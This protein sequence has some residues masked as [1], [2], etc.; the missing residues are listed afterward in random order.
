MVVLSSALATLQNSRA[1]AVLATSGGFLAPVLSSTGDGSHIALFSYYAVLNLGILTIAWFRS[2]RMLNVLGFGFTFV[3]GFMWGLKSY[4]SKMFASAEFFLIIFFFFYVAIAL[5]FAQRQAPNLRGYVD[6]TLIFGVPVVAFSIQAALVKGI[7]FALAFSALFLGFFYL[8]LATIYQKGLGRF[9]PDSKLKLLSE[10]FLA[11]GAIFASLTIPFAL[12]GEWI[13]SAWAL[14]GAGILWVSVKQNRKYGILFGL[15]LQV[16]G[17]FGFLEQTGGLTEWPVLNSIW[18]GASLVAS[19]GLFSSY[20]I[21]THGLTFFT[22][23]P[24]LS[25][26]FLIW[27]LLWWIVNGLLEIQ[28]FVPRSNQLAIILVFFSFTALGLSFL[29]HRFKW[30]ELAFNALGLAIVMLGVFLYFDPQ[31]FFKAHLLQL[32]QIPTSALHPFVNFGWVA[33]PIAFASLLAILYY[34]DKSKLPIH[35]SITKA[36]PALHLGALWL[37]SIIIVIDFAWVVNAV[38]K[39]NNAWLMAAFSLPVLLIIN[40]V[41]RTNFWPIRAHCTTYKHYGASILALYLVIWSLLANATGNGSTTPLPYI[42]LLN[43]LD[44]LQITGLI[45]MFYWWANYGKKLQLNLSSLHVYISL[46]LLGF[47]AFNASLVRVLHHWFDVPYALADIMN[48]N[49]TQAVLSIAWTLIGLT[50]MIVASKKHWREAWVAA[51]TLLGLTVTK[52]LLLDLA[53][54]ETLI[55]IISFI[56]VGML[57]LVV[58]YFSP[59]PPKRNLDTE[60]LN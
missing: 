41:M 5:L 16:L 24:K 12:D 40:S 22:F 54:R 1:L 4:E 28:T 56:V 13:A 50:A 10:S 42:P 49:L 29:E 20:Y 33:W 27:G 14:E 44:M 32:K 59:I 3:I 17:G 19:A 34:R 48:S 15:G 9:I 37:F 58:G 52:L 7:P 25:T 46:T 53:D 11:L 6:G 23:L 2:W 18:I 57:L 30:N 45:T 60:D 39:L 38:L 31:L 8:S 36:I 21:K 51:A 55:T 35:P 26:P 47:F 43:P